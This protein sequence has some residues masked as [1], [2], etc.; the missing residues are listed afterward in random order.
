MGNLEELEKVRI[1]IERCTKC[2]LHL[3]RR[4]P[5][6]GEGNPDAEVMVIG[7]APGRTE[8]EE[9]RPFVGAAGRL[10]NDV[11]RDLNV[12]RS[13]LFIT[14]VVKCRPPNNRDPTD[15]EV[16]ACTPYLVRQIMAIR[17]RK[18]ITL[19]RHSTRTIFKLGGLKFSDISSVRGRVYRVKLGGVEIEVYPTYHPAAA[20]YN[21]KLRDV[22]RGDLARAFGKGG[23]SSI[24]D[25]LS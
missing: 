6:P 16:E 9:G 18:I 7:E 14:N 21:P 8:D 13:S 4:R 25:Y 1:E 12:D 20:L 2:P 19:G 17:P 22:L 5:V 11:L 3:S 24:L 23:D 10:L 15:E